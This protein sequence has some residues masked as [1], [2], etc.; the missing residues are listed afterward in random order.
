MKKKSSEEIINKNYENYC[1]ELKWTFIVDKI[2][3]N[4]KIGR[5]EKIA[6]MSPSGEKVEVK[7]KKLQQYL[8]KGFTKV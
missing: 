8:N 4:E 1:N 6:L 7:Y 5:N 2:I 3:E